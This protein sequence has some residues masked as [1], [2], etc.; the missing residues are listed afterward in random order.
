VEGELL[1]A[2]FSESQGAS[3]GSGKSP[4][5]L[6]PPEMCASLYALGMM[7]SADQV[8]LF[9]CNTVLRRGGFASAALVLLAPALLLLLLFFFSF[10]FFFFFFLW[11]S[12]SLVFVSH[13]PLPL[14]FATCAFI[15]A[16]R[17]SVL[18]KPP[19]SFL[20]LC[21]CWATSTHLHPPLCSK[22]V[23]VS[24]VY[25]HVESEV[26]RRCRMKFERSFVSSLTLGVR[27]V[28]LPWLGH[29]TATTPREVIHHQERLGHLTAN[30]AGPAPAAPG[31]GVGGVVGGGGLNLF[32]RNNS[33]NIGFDF[34]DSG[35][36]NAAAAAAGTT[37]AT[38]PQRGHLLGNTA[39][40]L[41]FVVFETL[42]ALRI[43]ELFDI[44]KDYPSSR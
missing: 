12:R 37:A 5:S 21:C 30:P 27:E 19:A 44:I 43:D 18:K 24:I 7:E 14:Q 17:F 36:A 2:L 23:L 22:K 8:R 35:A 31:G 20:L 39:S 1:E 26:R 10:F 33:L 11:S 29:L 40:R 9:L 41:Q 42:G 4:W 16:P 34:S 13:R 38:A 32:S 3:G 28:I 25:N 6:T 15:C